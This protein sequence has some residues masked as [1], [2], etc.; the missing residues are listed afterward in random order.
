MNLNRETQLKVQ[1]WLDGELGQAD[2]A[3]VLR[4]VREDPRAAALARELKLSRKWLGVGEPLRPLPET[5]DYFWGK[6]AREIG[7]GEASGTRAEPTSGWGSWLRWLVPAAAALAVLMAVVLFR[8]VAAPRSVGV[9]PAEIETPLD[10]LGSFSFRSDS[11][12]MTIVWV[13]SF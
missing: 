13:D 2:V 5:R 11:E 9:R 10:D 3:G 4:Q 1:A 7:S 8:P 6:I 12:Q